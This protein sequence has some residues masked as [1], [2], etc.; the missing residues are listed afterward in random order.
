MLFLKCL[1]K[2]TIELA[3]ENQ[4]ISIFTHLIFV[5]DMAKHFQR[6]PDTNSRA[7]AHTWLTW[8]FYV[9]T[10]WYWIKFSISN[11]DSLSLSLSFEG[12]KRERWTI[13]QTKRDPTTIGHA[14]VPLSFP[15]SKIKS[16]PN[17]LV[18]CSSFFLSG[19]CNTKQFSV[20]VWIESQNSLY[21]FK[22]IIQIFS[23]SKNRVNANKYLPPPRSMGKKGLLFYKGNCCWLTHKFHETQM[24]ASKTASKC[25]VFVCLAYG[26]AWLN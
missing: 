1:I 13:H 9:C 22:E 21:I 14:S 24:L 16:Y 20:S 15:Y 6:N 7:H 11:I 4:S 2:N 25:R 10:S 5:K 18:F 23:S 19:S 17:S 12:K 26:S 3:N 8:C